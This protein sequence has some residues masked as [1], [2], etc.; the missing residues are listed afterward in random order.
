MSLNLWSKEKY[1]PYLLLAP[2]VLVWDPASLYPYFEPKILILDIVALFVFAVWAIKGRAEKNFSFYDFLILFWIGLSSISLL[3]LSHFTIGISDLL[4]R[5][6]AF[7][8]FIIIRW[9]PFRSK[10]IQKEFAVALI[11]LAEF[12]A[13]IVSVQWLISL[14]MGLN[15]WDNRLLLGTIGFHTFTAAFIGVCLVFSFPLFKEISL[16]QKI[17]LSAAYIHSFLVLILL[18]CRAVFLSLFAVI[19]LQV[20]I[21]I[22]ERAKITEKKGKILKTI[23]A[24]ILLFALTASLFLA[25]SEKSGGMWERT[26]EDIFSKKLTGRKLIWL[27]AFEMIKE[28]P[29]EGFGLGGFY[30]NYISYQGKVLSKNKPQSFYPVREMVIWAHDDFLQDFVE[31]GFLGIVLPVLMLFPLFYLILKL[32]GDIWAKSL[33]LA[34]IFFSIVCL[35]DFPL[36]RP[37]ESSLF[38]LL[39]AFAGRLIARKNGTA[40]EIKKGFRVILVSYGLLLAFF[41]FA[42]FYSKRVYAQG[43]AEPKANLTRKEELLKKSLRWSLRKGQTQAALGALLCEK[44]ELEE[45]ASMMEEG[46][47]TF[48]DVYIYENLAK[49]YL[50][51]GDYSKSAEYYKKA[52]DGGINYISDGAM[53]AKTKMVLGEKDEGWRILKVLYSL[54]KKNRALIKVLAGAYIEEK[55]YEKALE[56][57]EEGKVS[58]DLEILNLKAASLIRIGRFE[59]AEKTLYSAL[60]LNKKYVPAIVNLGVLKMAQGNKEAAEENFQNALRL[61]PQNKSALTNL[62]IIAKK[63]NK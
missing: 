60:S 50:E 22:F 31:L 14:S 53:F 52:M 61:D 29:I 56:I 42:D 20:L 51:I 58:D 26:K 48:R 54:S 18:Q 16:K 35:V 3:F 11:I 37:A 45:G 41:A 23:L 63:E 28:K 32:T 47:Q 44:G 38:M 13:I 40:V 9:F 10:N 46:L 7:S 24:G 1:I 57:I 43:I 33:A 36:H 49:L 34:I 15:F 6:S 19:F 30:H 39:A 25:T 27:S 12:E 8:L 5:L 4:L 17:F 62:S 21:Y 59:E 55:Q 2:L